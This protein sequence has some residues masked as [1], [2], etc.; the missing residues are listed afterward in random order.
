[1]RVARSSRQ[2]V[3]CPSWCVLDHGRLP[4]E[5]DTVH[6]SGALMVRRTVL[7]LCLT[8]DPGT[9]E[10]EGPYVLVGAEEYSLHEADALIDALTQLVDRGADVSPPAAP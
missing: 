5:D 4:G 6:V 10:R 3:T 9:G 1:M 7:R 2:P 8:H